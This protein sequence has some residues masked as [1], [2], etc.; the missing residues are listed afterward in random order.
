MAAAF[1]LPFPRETAIPTATQKC[2]HIRSHCKFLL[3]DPG[4]ELPPGKKGRR[5]VSPQSGASRVPF[6]NPFPTVPMLQQF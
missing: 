2:Q 1:L 5:E 3:N 4:F 6:C